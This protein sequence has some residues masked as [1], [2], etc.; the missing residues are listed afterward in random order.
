MAVAMQEGKFD[1]ARHAAHLVQEDA[2]NQSRKL[3][4]KYQAP[5]ENRGQSNPRSP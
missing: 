4:L 3:P 5:T 1:P 2:A